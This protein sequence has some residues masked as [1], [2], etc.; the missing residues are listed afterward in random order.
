MNETGKTILFILVSSIFWLARL[1][2]INRKLPETVLRCTSSTSIVIILLSL[3]GFARAQSNRPSYETRL[4]D[5]LKIDRVP[6]VVICFDDGYQSIY[7]YAYPLLKKYKMTAT[8]ALVTS[9]KVLEAHR[10]AASGSHLRYGFLNNAEVQEMIDSLSIEVA[11]HSVSHSSLI[12]I[13]DSMT[14]KSELVFSKQILESLFGQ[15]IITFVYPYG[16]YDDQVLRLTAEAGYRIGRT[17]EFGEPNF[18]VAPFKVPIKEVR[19]TTSIDEVINHLR[20]YDETVLL[21]H[22][23]LPKPLFFTEYRVNRFDSLLAVLSSL[24]AKVTTLR[25]LYDDW[26]QN[27]FEKLVLEKGSLD[28]KNWRDYLFQKVDIDLTRTSSRF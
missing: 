7:H 12:E 13:T 5:T 27:V 18:W 3:T 1:K 9:K 4:G 2:I 16:K 26:C 21:F 25:G 17:C 28:R 15:K 22:R 20:R 24:K 23:I 8:L 10:G 11:S 6:K 19:N 14:I